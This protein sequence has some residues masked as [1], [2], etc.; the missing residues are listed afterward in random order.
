MVE[1]EG[2]IVAEL[3]GRGLGRRHQRLSVDCSYKN[4]DIM[5]LIFKYL[6]K[7][8]H[9]RVQLLNKRI[10]YVRVLVITRSLF[11]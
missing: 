2:R 8:E 4:S 6:N 1:P 3:C 10:Y 11:V 5:G 7:Y 9:L